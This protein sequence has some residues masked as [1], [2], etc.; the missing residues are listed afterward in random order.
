[1]LADTGVD[2]GQAEA[3]RAAVGA[4]EAWRGRSDVRIAPV[5]RP[6]VTPAVGAPAIEGTV[7]EAPTSADGRR[8]VVDDA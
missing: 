1:M 3:V 2:A 7:L 5:D 8:V 4:L 6:E